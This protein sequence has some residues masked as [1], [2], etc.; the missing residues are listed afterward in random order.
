M[1]ST[2]PSLHRSP[3]QHVPFVPQYAGSAAIRPDEC[4]V[5]EA[6]QLCLSWVISTCVGGRYKLSV[7]IAWRETEE[8]DKSFQQVGS[9]VN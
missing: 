4:L 7:S 6:L 9:T 8:E 3:L 2:L 1:A 5:Y